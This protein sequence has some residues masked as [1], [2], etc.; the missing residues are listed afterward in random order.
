MQGKNKSLNLQG[1]II[2]GRNKIIDK[3][4]N[5][6]KWGKIVSNSNI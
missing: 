6:K 3:S 2:L 5:I 4:G 1:K